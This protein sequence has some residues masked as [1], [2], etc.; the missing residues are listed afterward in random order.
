MRPN[1]LA[2]RLVA[3]ATLWSVLALVVAGLI[4]ISLYRQTVEK[5]FDD[6]LGVYLKTLVGALGAQDPE[7]PLSDPG[8]LG[9]ARFEL[10]YSGW[11]WQVR[12]D[13]GGTVLLAS[14]SLFTDSLDIAKA[15]ATSAGEDDVTTGA[16]AGPDNQALRFVSRTVTLEGNRKLDFLVAGD[17]GELWTQIVSFGTSVAITLAVFGIG[18]IVAT[19]IQIRW[20]LRP[21]EEVRQSLGELRSGKQARIGGSYPAEIP[22]LVNELNALLE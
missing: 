7:T 19:L 22:P 2:R 14:K 12:A 6:R 10:L 21:L 15:T 3:A 20:G 9:E 11:Y 18:L 4:L 5:A 13:A 16:I 8:N 17:A 1:S